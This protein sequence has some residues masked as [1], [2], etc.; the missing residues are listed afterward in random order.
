MT[1]TEA[2]EARAALDRMI[3]EAAKVPH[4]E[5]DIAHARALLCGGAQFADRDALLA[6]LARQEQTL[7]EIA[8]ALD[9]GSKVSGATAL[10][11]IKTTQAERDRALT[12]A[13]SAWFIIERI[14]AVIGVTITGSVSCDL[15]ALLVAIA[16]RTAKEGTEP[17]TD[18]PEEGLRSRLNALDALAV[19]CCHDM[20]APPDVFTAEE[21][22][23][24][25]ADNYIIR[26]HLEN[27]LG[28]L[29][30]M[31][32][33]LG[34]EESATIGNMVNAIRDI[35]ESRAAIP[36]ALDVV[37]EIRDEWLPSVGAR[38][39]T[40]STLITNTKGNP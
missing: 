15:D 20:G 24:K 2:T 10:G 34:L 19:K 31:A 23:A 38:L 26:Q 11:A 18:A 3:R 32:E 5:A 9:L 4:L 37:A 30:E 22:I 33:V 1:P 7:D 39:G 29:D 8:R 28:E 35:T 21:I 17:H 13:R 12:D 6:A 14:G 25:A 40:Q 16:G 27:K 36:A